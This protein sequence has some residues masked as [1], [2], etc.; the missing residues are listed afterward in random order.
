L[1]GFLDDMGRMQAHLAG[2]TTYDLR[3]AIEELE[4]RGIHAWPSPETLLEL[5][6]SA[7]SRQC[8]RGMYLFHAAYPACG[9]PA[10]GE[11]WSSGDPPEAWR[12][13]VTRIPR[14]GRG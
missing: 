1:T 4:R 10:P 2:P 3:L 12:A 5:L 7:D 14:H 9:A 8:I 13:R 11:G 6:T